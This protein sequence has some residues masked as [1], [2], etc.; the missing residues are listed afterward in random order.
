MA[1]EGDLAGD[2]MDDLVALLEPGA[3]EKLKVQL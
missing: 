2:L 1:L 3:Q